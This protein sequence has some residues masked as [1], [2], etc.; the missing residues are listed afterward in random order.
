VP[1]QVIFHL[2][3]TGAGEPGKT[4]PRIDVVVVQR[5]QSD[6]AQLLCSPLNRGDRQ[7]DRSSKV[8][9]GHLVAPLGRNEQPQQDVPGRLAEDFSMLG[10]KMSASAARPQ[11]MGGKA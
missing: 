8:R 3:D 9:H 10:K 4:A 2:P 7:I 1:I 11:N 6:I 5:D